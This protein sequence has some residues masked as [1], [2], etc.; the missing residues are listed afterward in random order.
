MAMYVME[1]SGI[2]T[3]QMEHNEEIPMQ[4][5][6]SFVRSKFNAFEHECR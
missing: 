1:Q 2:K 5:I 3:N 4:P 6:F